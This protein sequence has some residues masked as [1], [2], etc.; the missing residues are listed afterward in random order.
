M[1]SVILNS[2]QNSALVNT[3]TASASLTNPQVYQTVPLYPPHS[4]TYSSNDPSNGGTPVKSNSTVFQLNKY[5][6]ISQI[7]FSFKKSFTNNTAGALTQAISTQQNDFFNIVEK[8]ELLSSSRVISTLTSRDF[9]AQFSNLPT[10][11]LSVIAENLLKPQQVKGVTAGPG[12]LA[13]GA[14]TP[15]A[16]F[17]CPLVFGFMKEINTQL[18]ASFLEPLSI[19]VTWG[20]NWDR[21]QAGTG[22]LAGLDGNI[23][24]PQLSVRYKNYQEDANAKIISEN[25]AN[26][27]LNILST[28]FQ[29][30]VRESALNTAGVATLDATIEVELKN[31]E[32][33]ENF[34]VILLKSDPNNGGPTVT[35]PSSLLL[36]KPHAI[37]SISFTGSGQEIVNLDKRQLAYSRLDTDGFSIGQED[38]ANAN[39]LSNVAKFQTGVYH[40]GVMS[41]T[42]S[43][44]EINNPRIKVTFDMDSNANRVAYYCYVVED[45]SAIYSITSATGSLQVSLS[46]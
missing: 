29:D 45:C 15:E 18:N 37:K 23:L 33:V 14:T 39:L 22:G 32:C 26:P 30:E 42:I 16:S 19:R 43:L 7:L 21:E 20:T 28:R 5:G 11:K 36:A 6:I 25:F 31:T 17:T 8:V 34:Y 12:D 27:Q 44:R 9:M 1:S 40:N 38:S 4:V 3:L 46:N 24:S 35:T 41:N 13:V 10:N 2:N